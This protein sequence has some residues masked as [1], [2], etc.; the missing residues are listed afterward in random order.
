MERQMKRMLAVAALVAGLVTI[1]PPADAQG[2]IVGGRVASAAEVQLPVGHG[3][4][5]GSWT[6]NDYGVSSTGSGPS[7][8][9]AAGTSHRRCWYVLDVQ[10]CE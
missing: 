4:Q 5:L 3:A 7:G 1:G 10:L 9:S 2:Y 6:V 8:Q